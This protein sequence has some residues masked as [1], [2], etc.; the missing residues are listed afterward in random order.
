MY[1]SWNVNF[2]GQIL[3]II[4]SSPPKYPSS[5]L[6]VLLN[7][8]KVAR[9]RPE[10]L[11]T[12]SFAFRLEMINPE[13]PL[14]VALCYLPNKM[15]HFLRFSLVSDFKRRKTKQNK[16]GIYLWMDGP[17]SR[18]RISRGR[19]LTT[20]ELCVFESEPYHKLI[21]TLHVISNLATRALDHVNEKKRKKIEKKEKALPHSCVTSTRAPNVSTAA[22]GWNSGGGGRGAVKEVIVRLLRK[23]SEVHTHTH[24]HYFTSSS[25]NIISPLQPTAF[26]LLNP[27]QTGSSSVRPPGAKD[28]FAS[29]GS[30]LLTRFSAL[31]ELKKLF[32]SWRSAPRPDQSLPVLLI[33]PNNCFSPSSLPPPQQ[34]SQTAEWIANVLVRSVEKLSQTMANH[35]KPK[36]HLNIC[37][38]FQFV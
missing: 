3:T 34:K 22:T 13:E 19:K 27:Q 29:P 32:L 31:K 30:F 37:H 14:A 4:Q 24:T 7:S 17:A 16:S 23:G 21:I 25:V 36:A 11:L 28:Y 9:R 6:L 2:S 35:D 10:S 5:T 26:L 18:G 12:S 15:Q 38:C 33:A 1:V 8:K 20:L